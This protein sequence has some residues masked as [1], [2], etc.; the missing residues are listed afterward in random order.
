[1]TFSDAFAEF[2]SQKSRPQKDICLAALVYLGGEAKGT[3]IK[4][5]LKAHGFRNAHSLNLH[6][7]LQRTEGMVV[8][9]AATWKLLAP[10]EQFIVA[11]GLDLRSTRSQQLDASLRSELDKLTDGNR[12]TFMLEA[13]SAFESKLYRAAVVLSWVGAVNVLHEFIAVNHLGAFKRAYEAR[14]PNSKLTVQNVA[15]LTQVKE[16]DFLQVCQDCGIIDKSVKNELATRLDL[17]NQAGH[18]N[19]LKIGENMAAAHI[20]CLLKNVFLVF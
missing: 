20:E 16:S 19:T 15:S 17:R 8:N 18:P 11:A 9:H 5:A 13:V 12:K 6:T 2:I 10:G 3:E 14:Y 7:A 1:M 4:A